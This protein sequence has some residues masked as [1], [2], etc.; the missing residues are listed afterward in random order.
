MD[1]S[2]RPP[3][4]EEQPW[5]EDQFDYVSFTVWQ[6]KENFNAWRKG[7][8]F[9]EAHG[10]TSI[11]AFLGTMVF[12]LC[13]HSDAE[14]PVPPPWP[15]SALHVES[16]MPPCPSPPSH[17]SCSPL[18]FFM[19]QL[20]RRID[21][22]LCFLRVFIW[23]ASSCQRFGPRWL[24]EQEELRLLHASDLDHLNVVLTLHGADHS[25]VVLFACCQLPAFPHPSCRCWFPI[26]RRS[27][28]SRVVNP[29]NSTRQINSAMLLESP[30][31]PAFFDG[32]LVQSTTPASVP[33]TV[34]GWRK[35]RSSTATFPLPSL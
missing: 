31:R 12:A 24:V 2:K 26:H 1:A 14:P 17:D 4:S 30:P 32:L 19:L 20:S 25:V 18:L 21:Q 28:R 23:S 11:S 34:D 3:T 13:S 9:R 27:T 16:P 8:A 29:T 5:Y 6:G 15:T 7:D 35:V 22:F 33:E 10:G